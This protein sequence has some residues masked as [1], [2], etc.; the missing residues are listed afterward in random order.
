MKSKHAIFPFVMAGLA[1][2]CFLFV[3]FCMSTYVQPP[4]G[5]TI[6]L[7]LPSLMLAFVG[8]L[9]CKGK[10]GPRKTERLTIILSILLAIVS[11]L[12]T[13][14]LSIWAATTVTTD[15]K[16]YPRAYQHVEYGEGVAGVFPKEIPADAQNV[17]FQYF[18]GFL[19]GGETLELSYSV[20][21]EVLSDWA[22]LLENRSQWYGSTE[23]WRQTTNLW[24]IDGEGNMLYQLYWDG[25][26][27]HGELTY[28]LIDPSCNQITFYY[29]NW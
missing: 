4:W 1:F 25:G 13:M 6:V 19:Q 23:E 5:E 2:L 26:H 12:Y 22:A 27:N 17:V 15:V 16:F 29:D 28:V 11:F 3:V 18:P 8:F 10:I 9:A 24:Y 14:M 20:T 7:I 21:D